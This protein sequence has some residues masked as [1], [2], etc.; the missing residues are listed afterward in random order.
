MHDRVMGRTT[1]ARTFAHTTD[2]D[3]TLCPL[4]IMMAGHEA[5]CLYLK[6]KLILYIL[7]ETLPMILPTMNDIPLV[8]PTFRF[9]LITGSTSVSISVFVFLCRS[10]AKQKTIK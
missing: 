8:I 4:V 10:S 9:N 3:N 5:L 7:P 6:V 1:H 2:R